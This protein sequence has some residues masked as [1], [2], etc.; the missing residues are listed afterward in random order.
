M[1]KGQYQFNFVEV[2]MPLNTMFYLPPY[3]IIDQHHGFIVISFFNE[4]R[5]YP[6]AGYVAIFNFV[7]YLYR[8][9][10]A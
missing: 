10:C 7:L 8:S 2:Y 3:I 1:H 9:K 5:L 4:I 6:R